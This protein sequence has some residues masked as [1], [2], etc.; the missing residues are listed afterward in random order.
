M[1]T[2]GALRR[3]FWARFFPVPLLPILRRA[4]RRRPC[5]GTAPAQQRHG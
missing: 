3:R 4:R 5:R 2:D 1:L